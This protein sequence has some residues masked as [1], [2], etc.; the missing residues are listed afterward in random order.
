MIWDLV[1]FKLENYLS[2]ENIN[3]IKI[4]KVEIFK[5]IKE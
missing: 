2:I 5:L 1:I 4:M 3:R